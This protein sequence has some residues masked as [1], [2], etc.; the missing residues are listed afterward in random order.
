LRTNVTIKFLCKLAVLWVKIAI[1]SPVVFGEDIFKNDNIG[2]CFGHWSNV[3]MHS[4][5]WTRLYEPVDCMPTRALFKGY[6]FKGLSL[7]YFGWNSATY[8]EQCEQILAK[9]R[10]FWKKIVA[11]LCKYT[12]TNFWHKMPHLSDSLFLVCNHKQQQQ[13]IV[14]SNRYDI[15]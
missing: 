5:P 9:F 6:L 3:Q 7:C 11:S 13:L 10:K 1:F 2:P 8:R 12:F 14:L 15:L 4:V